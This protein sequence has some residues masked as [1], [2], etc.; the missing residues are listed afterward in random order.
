MNILKDN[1]SSLIFKMSIPA[2]IGMI[3]NTFYNVID[4]YFA[5]Q[6][7]SN[8]LAGMSISFPIYL[9]LMAMGI[10]FQSSSNTFRRRWRWAASPPA[11]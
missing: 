1:L 7:S 11:S 5:G 3:F 4:T 9:I 2:T 10:G 6:L 8:A